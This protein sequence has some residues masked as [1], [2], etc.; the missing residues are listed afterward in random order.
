MKKSLRMPASVKRLIWWGKADPV[1]AKKVLI[2]QIFNRGDVKDIRWVFRNY[3]K[4]VLK[5]CVQNPLR[6]VWDEKSLNLFTGLFKT[7]LPKK[8]REAALQSILL[9]PR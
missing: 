8:T 5:D 1:N 2:T 3:P 9:N 6:G 4:S 7:R